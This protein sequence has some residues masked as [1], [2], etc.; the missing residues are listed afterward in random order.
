MF[1]PYT[2]N[3][4]SNNKIILQ[5]IL[6]KM[7]FRSQEAGWSTNYQSDLLQSFSYDMFEQQ[8]FIKE[9]SKHLSFKI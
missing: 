4:M 5:L 6:K 2:D 3:D 1:L 8:L 9:K 7:Y